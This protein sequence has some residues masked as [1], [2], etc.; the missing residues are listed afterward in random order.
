MDRKRAEEGQGQ[1]YI[2][3]LKLLLLLIFLNGNYNY[4]NNN[5]SWSL[6]QGTVRDRFLDVQRTI[7]EKDHGDKPVPTN[8]ASEKDRDPDKRTQDIGFGHKIT[9]K[10]MREGEIYDI[11]FIDSDGNYIPLTQRQKKTI[12]QKDMQKHLAL[13]RKSGWDSKLK[14][15]GL[16]WDSLDE[17]Y[18]LALQDLAYNVGGPDAGE[19]WTDIFD[20]I[21][22]QDTE[23]FVRQLRRQDDGE[24]TRGMDN[25]VAI[26]AYAL[27][28]IRN[29][30]EAH[31]AGLTLANTTEVPVQITEVEDT[32]PASIPEKKPEPPLTDAGLE[33]IR[34]GITAAQPNVDAHGFGLP[35]RPSNRFYTGPGSYEMFPFPVPREKPF[36]GFTPIQNPPELFGNVD[37]SFNETMALLFNMLEKENPGR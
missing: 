29:L 14:K 1:A 7:L 33:A 34:R 35:T 13:A 16:S 27:G 4:M 28:L 6:P 19:D 2:S 24:N 37:P 12:Q 17:A 21:E 8:D 22:N 18:Q 11:P 30:E 26:V 32:K 15:R 25:R 10:E 3:L 23:D 5:E 9:K 36:F 20:A 31:N